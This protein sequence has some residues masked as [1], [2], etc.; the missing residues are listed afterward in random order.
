MRHGSQ[1][2]RA[3]HLQINILNYRLY[4]LWR[5]L[6]RKPESRCPAGVPE[7]FLHCDTLHLEH[8]A[9]ELVVKGGTGRAFPL[10]PVG[11]NGLECIGMFMLGIHGESKL[12]EI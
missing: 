11:N 7:T 6:E 1:Y 3:A 8:D 10:L 5:E 2:A 4:L 9:I 12:R